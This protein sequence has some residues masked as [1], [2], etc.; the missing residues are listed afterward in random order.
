[1]KI[2]GSHFTGVTAVH[3]GATSAT[4]YKVNSATSITAA[5][6]AVPAGTVDV[7][8]T[9]TAGTSALVSA[10]RFKFFP[11]VSGVSPSAGSTKGGTSVTLT[12]AGFGVG[13]GATTIK[14]GTAKATSVN[15][16][17]ETTCTAVS[18]AHAAGTVD[19]KATV[20]GVASPKAPGDRFTYS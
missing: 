6:P 4:S 8:V 18:P 3:F 2:T 20:S 13:T 11:T 17:S 14:F 10:D 12:G 15:C 16:V 1:V 5:T 7:S 9:T 19:V